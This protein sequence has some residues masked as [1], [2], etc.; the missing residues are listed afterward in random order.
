MVSDAIVDFVEL[1]R[2]VSHCSSQIEAYVGE[3]CEEE[4]DCSI[5]SPLGREEEFP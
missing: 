3:I 2:S 5:F 1:Y 4:P